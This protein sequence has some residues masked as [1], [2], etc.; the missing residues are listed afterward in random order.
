MEIDLIQKK[1]EALTLLK[2][3]YGY[4]EFY[5]T[6]WD[7]ISHIITGQDA[8]VLMPTGG[9]KSLC[10]QIPALMLEGCT[11]VVSPLLALMTDQVN[12]LLANGIPAAAVNSQ[13]TDEY[14][15][16]IIENAYAGNI[17]WLYISPEKL[18]TELDTWSQSFKV[19]LIAIDEAHCISQ[20]GHDFRP[21]YARLGVL[22]ERFSGVPIMALTATA[23]RLTRDDIK[24][25]LKINDARMFINSFDRPN[26]SLNVVANTSGAQ[27]MTRMVRFIEKHR[28]ESGIIYCLSRKSTESL[29]AD[30]CRR[31]YK[32]AA[33]HAT[34]PTATKLKVQKAFVNDEITI[35]CATIAFGMGIDK[36]NVRWV[37]HNNMPKNIEG[38][39]Q[40]IGRAGRDGMPA[41]TLMFYSYADVIQLTKFAQDSGQSMVNMDK[42]R[43]MQQYAES[44]VC[45]RRI[46]LNYFNEPYDHNCNN[47][48]VCK[49]PPRRI[50]GTIPAQMLLSAIARTGENVG[51]TT[52][53]DIVRGL[54]K[55][56]I[57]NKGYH[58]L[59]TF[60]VGRNLSFATF[61]GYMLQ[62]LQLGLIDVAYDENKHIKITPMGREV[63]KGQ[64]KV[65]FTE[66]E[67]HTR[68]AEKEK[69]Q[70]VLI[71]PDE[72]SDKQLLQELKQMRTA[73]ARAEG[74]P[75]YIIFSDKTLA[76]IAE[77]K[78]TTKAEFS[79]LYGVGEKKTEKY[80]RQFTS[81]VRKSLNKQ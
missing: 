80:W 26:I 23:D 60:G 50:D 65:E 1:R 22:R 45:R 16:Q 14:N 68:K 53:I 48:D 59:P 4:N 19:S 71:T 32:A 11:I 38:Y 5:P 6:Q 27:K 37:I 15:R 73:I 33:F 13:Q 67:Y 79:V 10:Y 2:Q 3:F 56:E 17:K 63:L 12:A 9:G 20:W 61:N 62:M 46:L 81:V 21:E 24:T 72:V 42:L 35:I 36:S 54:N 57:M 39:Y 51:M 75:P 58:R 41:D 43:R 40:E 52:A 74:M 44:G 49:N 77:A 34:L 70:P 69:K 29:A 31:G 76:A 8:V 78:P 28:G 7:V 66:V 64:R 30:L 25:Q 55:A 18:L 47:C